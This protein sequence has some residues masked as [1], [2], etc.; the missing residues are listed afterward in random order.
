[1]AQAKKT[2]EPTEAVVVEPKRERSK[3]RIRTS[4][5]FWGFAFIFVG[6]LLLLDNLHL[7]T[8][9]FNNLWQLWPILVIG[10]GVS[11][12]SLRGWLSG[13]ISF[14]LAIAFGVL[15]YLV[16]V[17]NPYF[18]T[19]GE[20]TIVDGSAAVVNDKELDLTL[21]TG[22]MEVS[23]TSTPTQSGY[24]AQLWSNHLTLEQ[25][26]T[27]SRDG[28]RYVILETPSKSAWWRGIGESNLVLEFTRQL[29][30]S[31]HIDAG[32]SSITGDVSAVQLRT[33]TIK[34]G[35]SSVAIRFGALQSRQNVTVEAGASS[36]EFALPKSIG[37][38]V[39]TDKGLSRTDFEGID[40]VADGVYESAGFASAERQITIDAKMGVSSFEITRY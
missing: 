30:V 36:V 37:V 18:T 33:M 16:A 40:K 7:I 39:E 12:L 11:M 17:E 21:R 14:V 31:L 5:I 8:V 20:Q 25:S 4:S 6:L 32:A 2:E 15:A 13:I 35:A 22:A 10:T 26:K 19:Q 29:P 1:M 34:T 27:E 9:H 3:K 38:R 24:L 28:V 23:I